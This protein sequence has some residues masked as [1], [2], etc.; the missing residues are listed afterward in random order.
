MT[1][2]LI[3]KFRKAE[4]IKCHK[5]IRDH[6]K[7]TGNYKTHM[8]SCNPE[9]YAEY[10]AIKET[11]TQATYMVKEGPKTLTD[12]LI[13]EYIIKFLIIMCSLPYRLV[14]TN[15]FRQFMNLLCP[16]WKPINRYLVQKGIK[17]LKSTWNLKVS[18]ILSTVNNISLAV[19]LWSDRKLRSYLGVTAHFFNSDF[20]LKSIVLALKQ[21]TESHSGLNIYD[22]LSRIICEYNIQNKIFKILTDNGANLLSAIRLATDKTSKN[23]EVDSDIDS[24][25]SDSDEDE[26]DQLGVDQENTIINT[27]SEFYGLVFE[28]FKEKSLRCFNH[29][30]QLVIK[31]ST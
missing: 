29:T 16:K 28:N 15:G 14:E 12:E 18:A 31:K 19:D 30:L 13:T 4:C 5:V 24:E 25:Y 1:L 22:Q 23:N 10:K 3:G 2:S 27:Q 6:D 26:G 7:S 9:K 21:F 20:E 8:I 17:K 11:K